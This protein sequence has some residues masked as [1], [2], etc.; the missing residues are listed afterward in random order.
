[1]VNR[2]FLET[3]NTICS[4]ISYVRLPP[5]S[6]YLQQSVNFLKSAW[7]YK[8]CNCL[9]SHH[10]PYKWALR[11]EKETSHQLCVW[12]MS[13]YKMW[14]IESVVPNLVKLSII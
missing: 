12:P 7:L 3:D 5:R 6:K 8:G 14:Q 9:S 13:S 11:R 10:T 2:L 4:P 1:M